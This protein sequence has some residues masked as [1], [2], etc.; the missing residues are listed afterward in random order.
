M[1]YGGKEEAPQVYGRQVEE[2]ATTPTRTS[3]EYE[4]ELHPDDL[5]G[6]DPRNIIA[7]VDHLDAVDK[8]LGDAFGFSGRRRIF[9][10][11]FIDD[12][13]IK[14]DHVGFNMPGMSISM[15]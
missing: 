10:R 12:G 14:D 8:H 11:G 15:T 4:L 5:S 6:P 9:G 1:T 7:V 13:G 2:P 3:L